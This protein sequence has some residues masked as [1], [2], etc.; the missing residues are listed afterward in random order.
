MKFVSVRDIRG[1]TAQLWR[2]LEQEQDL[3]V[4]NN[5]KPVAILSATDGASLERALNDIRRC[6]A[7][8][9]LRQIQR[10]AARRRL[11]KLSIE[12]IDAEIQASRKRRR[13]S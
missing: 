9:A 11:D 1:S 5:G 10:D 8:G 12:E 3:V 6:R 2:D 13:A 7:D 4:T